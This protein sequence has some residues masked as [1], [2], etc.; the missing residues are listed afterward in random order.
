MLSLTVDTVKNAAIVVV[1]V[2]AVLAIVAASL[3]RKVVAKLIVVALV[4]II[5]VAVW[6]QRS[7]LQNCATRA[8][9]RA[10]LGDKASVVCSFFGQSVTVPTG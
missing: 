2:L 7:S 9:D 10:A 1:V 5:G 6:S 8:K 4:V 3:I